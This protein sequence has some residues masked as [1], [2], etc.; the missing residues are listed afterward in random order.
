M[1]E[2]D[3]MRML[4]RYGFVLLLTLTVLPLRALDAPPLRNLIPELNFQNPAG[5][6]LGSEG[7]HSVGRREIRRSSSGDPT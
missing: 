7:D 4:L 3:S 5:W 6:S 2:F 1:R